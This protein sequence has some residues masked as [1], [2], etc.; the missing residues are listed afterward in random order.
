[1]ETDR[2]IGVPPREKFTEE[3]K[4]YIDKALDFMTTNVHQYL[5]LLKERAGNIS[6]R[7]IS[8]RTGVSPT[9]ISDIEGN[10]YLPKMEVLL[11]LAYGMNSDFSTML[12]SLWKFNDIQNWSTLTNT[13]VLMKYPMQQDDTD[14]VYSDDN[15]NKV[16]TLNDLLAKEGLTV[17]DIREV[18]EFIEF[19]K[20]RRKRR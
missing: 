19:K 9:V 14:F 8:R 13:P 2:H 20:S 5:K 6:S 3:D 18:L 16:A 7:E 4:K 10:K 15:E 12:R 11:K 17:N 1:M